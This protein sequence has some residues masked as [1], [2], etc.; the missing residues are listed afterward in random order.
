MTPADRTT[1]LLE[2]I[3][4]AL[5]KQLSF[6]ETHV[7]QTRLADLLLTITDD[8]LYETGVDFRHWLDDW[9][10]RQRDSDYADVTTGRLKARYR[11]ALLLTQSLDGNSN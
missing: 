10:I 3:E 1:Q 11:A 6:E 5:S 9:D 8:N 4:E 2:L 7:I